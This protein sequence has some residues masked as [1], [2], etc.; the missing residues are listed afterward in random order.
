MKARRTWQIIQATD[1]PAFGKKHFEIPFN[2]DGKVWV[3][4]AVWDSAGNG[5]V[6]Q[7]IKLNA[8]TTTAAR[9]YGRP[10]GRPLRM[11]G[12]LPA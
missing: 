7:P 3:R 2:A 1:L 6:V 4:F 12:L 8:V 10:K 9:L 11:V 5:A